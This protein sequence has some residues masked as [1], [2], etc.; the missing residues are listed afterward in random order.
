MTS[1]RRRITVFAIGAPTADWISMAA[2]CRR[3]TP[4]PVTDI[5]RSAATTIPH[6]ITRLLSAT[7]PPQEPPGQAVTGINTAEATANWWIPVQAT[8]LMCTVPG[9]ITVQPST[10]ALIPALT[11]DKARIAMARTPHRQNTHRT[12]PHSIRLAAIAPPVEATSAPL[13]IR[14]TTSSTAHGA[15]TAPPSTGAQRPVP[16]AVTAP[17]SIQVTLCPTVIGKSMRVP[18]TQ[19]HTNGP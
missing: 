9:P 16:T 7:I 13:P 2:L 15:I 11:A 12:V 5:A 4:I 10:G 1:G 3:V 18:I 19:I 17:M 14:V 8:G 6:M